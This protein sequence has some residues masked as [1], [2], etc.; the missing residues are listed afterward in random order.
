VRD[1]AMDE[2]SD[3]IIWAYAKSNGYTIISKDEDFLYLASMDA[4]SPS[5]VWVR[6]GNCR[7]EALLAA[8]KK[9]L[10]ELIENLQ[11]GRKVVE[12]R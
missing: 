12:I 2:T 10:P 5:F 4:D 8:F 1:L 6:L 9:V 7:K 11:A 3:H